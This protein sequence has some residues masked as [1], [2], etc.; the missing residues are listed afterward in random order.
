MARMATPRTVVV[1]GASAGVGRAAAI[2]F[3]RRG[4]RVALIARGHEGLYGAR[5]EIEALGAQALLL[6]LDV[7]DADAVERAAERVERELG[8]IEVWVNAAMATIFAP[9]HRIRADEYRR[10]TDVTYLGTVHG[11]S[12][13]HISEPTRP[14]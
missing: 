12:L 4:A 5:R 6:P 9:V 14:Y 3:A 8:P 11:L 2:E 13:I 1:T 10:A 7:A